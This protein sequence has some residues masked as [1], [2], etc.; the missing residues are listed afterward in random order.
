MLYTLKYTAVQYTMCTAVQYT[1]CKA[2][3]Y[4]LYS[5]DHFYNIPMRTAYH[6]VKLYSIPLCMQLYNIPIC[7]NLYNIPLCTALKFTMC[8][9]V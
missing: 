6:S 2:V 1:M 3:Q 7:V 8:T 5:V 9:A 4:T